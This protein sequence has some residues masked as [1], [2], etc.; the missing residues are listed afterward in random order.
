MSIKVEDSGS[1]T[2]VRE[3]VPG[4]LPVTVTTLEAK[5]KGFLF[6]GFYLVRMCHVI[7]VRTDLRRW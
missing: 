1:G 4:S 5:K 7:L 3:K 2:G 6:A